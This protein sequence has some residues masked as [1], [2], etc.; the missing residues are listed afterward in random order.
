MQPASVL[1]FSSEETMAG[2]GDDE[3]P[4]HIVSEDEDDSAWTSSQEQ[5]DGGTTDF[6]NSLDF[7]V[8][9]KTNLS[10]SVPLS[11][12]FYLTRLVSQ[13]IWPMSDAG[14]R[15]QCLLRMMRSISVRSK[16]LRLVDQRLTGNSSVLPMRR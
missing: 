7:S 5:A 2:L 3:N 16:L 14:R 15:F 9:E 4:L 8:E 13:P 10:M 6:S 1:P 12:T 11:W